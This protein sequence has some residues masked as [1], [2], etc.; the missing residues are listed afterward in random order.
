M[1]LIDQLRIHLHNDRYKA[2]KELL[3][4]TGPKLLDL[5]CGRPCEVMPDGSFLNFLGYGVGL[6]LKPCR[7]SWPFCQGDLE[8]L[9]F[10]E[11]AFDAVTALEVLEHI[12]CPELALAEIQRLLRPGGILIMGSPNHGWIFKTLW[13]LWVRTFGRMWKETHKSDWTR[14]RWLQLFSQVPGFRLIQIRTYWGFLFIA[15]LEKTA[16]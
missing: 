2:A 16:P 13:A 8:A 4:G 9:P 11:A 5:G 15:K 6:D 7:L 3:D 12:P 10:K 14:R 1:F